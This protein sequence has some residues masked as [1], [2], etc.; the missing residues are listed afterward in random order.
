[1]GQGAGGANTSASSSPSTQAPVSTDGS[2][3]QNRAT[4]SAV[5]IRFNKDP[6]V[7]GSTSCT[8][9]GGINPKTITML[10][11]LKAGCKCDIQITGGSEPIGHSRNSNHGV[12]KEAVDISLTEPLSTFLKSN[13]VTTDNRPPCNIKYV[14]GG[15]TF[16]DEA[17]DCD[18]IGGARHFHVSFTGR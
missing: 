18:G 15:F 16:W 10:L 3:Q 14:W 8:N 12:G 17:K 4:L 1:V 7:A 5:G 11:D 9:V 2:E 6:C 13:G